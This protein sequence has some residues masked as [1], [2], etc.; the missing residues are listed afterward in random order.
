MIQDMVNIKN[1]YSHNRCFIRKLQQ[2]FYNQIHIA[3]IFYATLCWCMVGLTSS[4]LSAIF[5][6]RHSWQAVVDVKS[7][8]NNH[9]RDIDL[10]FDVLLNKRE[11]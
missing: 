9:T 2:T 3:Q 11:H 7:H 10:A 5:L 8:N 4:Q 1:I 6:S